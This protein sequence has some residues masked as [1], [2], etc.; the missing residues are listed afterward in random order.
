MDV[1]KFRE[2]V[3]EALNC[4]FYYDEVSEPK[5]KY[6]ITKNIRI[7]VHD[8]EYVDI[9]CNEETITIEF[10]NSIYVDNLRNSMLYLVH[11]EV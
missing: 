3:E 4:E 9:V 8:R 6:D 7:Y 5:R 10:R 2:L 11:Y 1:W